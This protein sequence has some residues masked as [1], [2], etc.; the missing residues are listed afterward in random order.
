[1]G[2]G[3]PNPEK[4]YEMLYKCYYDFVAKVNKPREAAYLTLSW[5]ACEGIYPFPWRSLTHL[6]D[7]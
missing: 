3:N 4:A 2:G 1:M 7:R 5:Q 6:L